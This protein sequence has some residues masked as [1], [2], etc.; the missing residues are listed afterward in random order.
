MHH[1]YLLAYH[2]IQV[3]PTL[4][5]LQAAETVTEAVAEE[6]LETVLPL[7]LSPSANDWVVEIRHKAAH[8]PKN[9]K[10]L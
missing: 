8:K 3:L 1:H 10:I 2:Y 4:L 6:V 5:K 7:L 9:R